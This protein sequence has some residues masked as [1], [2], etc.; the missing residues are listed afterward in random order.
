MAGALSGPGALSAAKLWPAASSSAPAVRKRVMLVFIRS[1]L[2]VEWETPSVMSRGTYEADRESG[3]TDHRKFSI[4]P[5]ASR[6][7]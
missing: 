7:L 4:S 6:T 1:I 2:V 3:C 5:G